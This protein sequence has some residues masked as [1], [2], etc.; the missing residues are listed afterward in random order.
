MN[1]HN[2]LIDSDIRRSSIFDLQRMQAKDRGSSTICLS[3]I[4]SMARKGTLPC[5]Y[6]VSL[7]Y[8]PTHWKDLKKR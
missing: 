2:K 7:I 6:L 8:L 3:D 4:P 5:L 1:R